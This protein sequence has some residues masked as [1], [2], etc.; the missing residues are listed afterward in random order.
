MTRSLTSAVQLI[1]ASIVFTA[2]I[3]ESK[4]LAS[5]AML[6][7]II[8]N[9]PTMYLRTDTVPR[10]CHIHSLKTISCGSAPL[11]SPEHLASKHGAGVGRHV[12]QNCYESINQFINHV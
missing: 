10:L 4:A 6:A 7:I 11:V 3:L 1:W 9:V 2:R 8:P 12:V 5:F